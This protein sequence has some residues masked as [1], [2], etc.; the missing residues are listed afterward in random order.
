MF[1]LWRHDAFGVIAV[2]QH[3]VLFSIFEFYV[4]FFP[5]AAATQ[6]DICLVSFLIDFHEHL[7][8][9]QLQPMIS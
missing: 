8:A 4:F 7:T 2:S 1:R 9:M 6:I 5:M 3:Y